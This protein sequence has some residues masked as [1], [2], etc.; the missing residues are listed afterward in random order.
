MSRL[1]GTPEEKRAEAQRIVQAIVPEAK[2]QVR[3]GDNQIRCGLLDTDDQAK[4]FTVLLK[5]LDKGILE[6]HARMLKERL[7]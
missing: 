3:G 5:N 7:R 1:V 2:C 4:S 6:S